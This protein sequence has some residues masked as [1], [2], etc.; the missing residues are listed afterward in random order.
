MSVCLGGVFLFLV[1]SILV[2]LFCKK[3]QNIT[4]DKTNVKAFGTKFQEK[5]PRQTDTQTRFNFILSILE[6]IEKRKQQKE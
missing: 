2:L 6:R 4:N 3:K 1:F 5:P